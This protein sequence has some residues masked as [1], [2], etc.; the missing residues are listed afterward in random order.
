LKEIINV[1]A[2]HVVEGAEL[3]VKVLPATG[4]KCARCWNF[5]P[6][7]SGYGVWENVCTRCQTALTEM[8]VARPEP[9]EQAK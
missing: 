4:A 7:V 8:A 9:S 5:M 2:V 1:S 6:E 3:A